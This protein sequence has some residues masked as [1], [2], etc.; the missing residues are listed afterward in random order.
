M[1]VFNNDNGYAWEPREIIVDD[2]K[3]YVNNGEST[4]QLDSD[5]SVGKPLV[6]SYTISTKL[7]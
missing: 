1:A 6:L 4:N 3:Q 7:D 2:S 5:D